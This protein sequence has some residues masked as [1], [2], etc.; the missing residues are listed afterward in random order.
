MDL[1]KGFHDIFAWTYDDLKEYDN[2]IF[3]Y[4]IPLKEG[5]VPMRKKPRMMNPKLKPLFKIELEKMEKD[6]IIFSLRNLEWISNLVVVRKKNGSICIC[7]NFWDLNQASLKDNY[8]LPYMES[9][10]QQV[11]GSELMSMLD[12]F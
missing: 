10:L 11:I 4:V 3:D 5:D 2:D 6:R 1:F 7:A 8:P 9:L 12:K